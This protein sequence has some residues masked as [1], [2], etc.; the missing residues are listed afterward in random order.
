MERRGLMVDL[1]YRMITL[2]KEFAFLELGLE[3][4]VMSPMGRSR[5]EMQDN[6]SSFKD[7]K[8]LQKSALIP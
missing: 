8:P 3:Y 5:I 7:H 4:I 6:I 2:V 1:G